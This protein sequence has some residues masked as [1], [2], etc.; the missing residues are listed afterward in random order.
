MPNDYFSK[1]LNRVRNRFNSV[2]ADQ[3]TCDLQLRQTLILAICWMGVLKKKIDKTEPKDLARPSIQKFVKYKKLVN[4]IFDRMENEIK[5][6]EI[7][8]VEHT[9]QAAAC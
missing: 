7:K 8:N 3:I 2:F 1:E 9:R 5:K 6:K 4:D